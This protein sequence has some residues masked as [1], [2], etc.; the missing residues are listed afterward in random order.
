VRA[1]PPAIDWIVAA[2]VFLVGENSLAEF[3]ERQLAS[4]ISRVPVPQIFSAERAQFLVEA[5]HGR[6]RAM[7][8]PI[9]QVAVFPLAED[10]RLPQLAEMEERICERVSPRD[11]L[12]HPHV[13]GSKPCRT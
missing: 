2:E 12:E 11:Q 7:R 3:G 4:Q 6:S 13:R 10:A 5:F 9:Q 8:K 1:A